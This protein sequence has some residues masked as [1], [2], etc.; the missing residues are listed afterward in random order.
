M[1]SFFKLLNDKKF[2]TVCSL[3]I[4]IFLLFS[5]KGFLRNYRGFDGFIR[6]FKDAGTSISEFYSRY[7][8]ASSYE[9]AVSEFLGV[10]VNDMELQ[11]PTPD[12]VK[13]EGVLECGSYAVVRISLK[14]D[15]KRNIVKSGYVGKDFSRLINMLIYGREVGYSTIF[16]AP[17]NMIDLYS[18]NK[19]NNEDFTEY[20]IA[21][22]GVGDK[23][24]SYRD[25]LSLFSCY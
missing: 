16:E 25:N 6:L 19:V 15:M 17:E 21:I 12:D 1:S 23:Y 8:E 9:G 5:S 22:E 4:V 2:R 18:T 10:S 13:A 20:V 14:S 7:K 3:F 24:P 11:Q